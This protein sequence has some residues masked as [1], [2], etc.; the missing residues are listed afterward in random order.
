MDSDHFA[1]DNISQQ[2]MALQRQW[3]EL[4]LLASKRTQKLNDAMEAQKVRSRREIMIFSFD[5]SICVQQTILSTT[6]AT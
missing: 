6:H 2:Q 3:R 5:W 4:K 1:A